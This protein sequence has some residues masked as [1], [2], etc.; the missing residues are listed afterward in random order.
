MI[1]GHIMGRENWVTKTRK[2]WK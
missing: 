1:L 2:R